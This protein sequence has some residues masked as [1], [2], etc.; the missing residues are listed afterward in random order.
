MNFALDDISL[1]LCVFERQNVG[2]L[3][4]GYRRYALCDNRT[5]LEVANCDGI[6][7]I[8]K[9]GFYINLLFYSYAL[10]VE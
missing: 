5:N 9:T 10:L 1:W 2:A 7:A 3:W 8:A 6:P 4:H